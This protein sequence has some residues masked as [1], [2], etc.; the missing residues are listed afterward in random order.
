MSQY[1]TIKA[2]MAHSV[3]THETKNIETPTPPRFVKTPPVGKMI[4]PS[5]SCA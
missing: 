5:G 3:M 2:K 1:A 4:I